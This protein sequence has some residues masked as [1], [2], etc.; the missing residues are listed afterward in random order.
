[1]LDFR[2]HLN[3]VTSE[4]RHL[5]KALT[6]RLLSSNKKKQVIDE[7]LNSKY[8]AT[9]LGI[10]TDNQLETIDKLLNKAARNTLG[11][12]PS[13]STEEIHGHTTEM[14]LGYAPMKDRVTQMGIEHIT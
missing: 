11:L 13:F 3:H 4:V 6:K 7:L 5:A 10:F 2:D 12:I 8:H 14:G 1:M 9:H